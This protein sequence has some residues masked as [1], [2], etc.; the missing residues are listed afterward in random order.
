MERIPSR[1]L[2]PR[3]S[4][5]KLRLFCSALWIRPSALLLSGS[6]GRCTR[7]ENTQADPTKKVVWLSH[8]KVLDPGS[9]RFGDVGS[10]PSL[11]R[12]LPFSQRVS[13]T[14]NRWNSPSPHACAGSEIP[15]GSAQLSS[16]RVLRQGRQPWCL[17]Q[18]R[19][20]QSFL[21]GDGRGGKATV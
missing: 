15:F 17:Q 13:K 12:L 21:G 4:C 20:V 9:S 19:W 7:K 1:R 6:W 8:S 16:G 10:N 2:W 18:V 3:K 14:K 11:L 5:W